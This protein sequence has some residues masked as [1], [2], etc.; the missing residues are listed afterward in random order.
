M[1]TFEQMKQAKVKPDSFTYALLLK[2]LCKDGRTNNALDIFNEMKKKGIT[3][4]KAAYSTLIGYYSQKG[5]PEK[6]AVCLHLLSFSSF[7][8]L[9]PLFPSFSSSPFF[10]IS[11]PSPFSFLQ[12]CFIY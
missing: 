11:L 3:N 6:C 4:N 1:E 8:S 2:S 5:E 9:L 7:P 10:F 12:M